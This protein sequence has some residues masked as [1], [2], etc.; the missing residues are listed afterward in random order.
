L[1]TELQVSACYGHH[2][3]PLQNHEEEPD[4][5]HNKPKPV[6]Q[7]PNKEIQRELAVDRFFVWKAKH[8][9]TGMLN[10]K[11]VKSSEILRHTDW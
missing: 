3:V 1:E 2:Q 4:D 5:T 9:P 10:I 8:T 11:I 6:A 7:S